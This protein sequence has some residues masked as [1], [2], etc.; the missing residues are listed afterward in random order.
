MPSFKIQIE[1]SGT[2][3]QLAIT[4]LEIGRKLQV[5]DVYGKFDEEFLTEMNNMQDDCLIINIEQD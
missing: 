1:L 2:P 3:N 5:Q 4:L